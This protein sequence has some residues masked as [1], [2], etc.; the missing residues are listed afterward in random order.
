MLRTVVFILVLTC[1]ELFARSDSDMDG[2]E[3]RIDEC[4]NTPLSELVDKDGCTTASLYREKSFDFIY[5]VSLAQD[6]YDATADE[7]LDTFS[8]SFQF[9]YYYGDYSFQ[10]S[11]SVYDSQGETYTQSGSNDSFLGVYYKLPSSSSLIV[12]LGA[13]L[14]LPTYSSTLYENNT[15]FAASMNLSY[16]LDEINL[17]GAYCYTLINDKNIQVRNKIN[18]LSTAQINFQ[19]T[20]SLSAGLGFYPIE[21]LYLSAAYNSSESIYQDIDVMNTAS[22]GAF[23]NLNENWFTTAG[24]AYGLSESASQSYIS[25]RLGYY[26]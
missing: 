19:N 24:Y 25:L 9:D 21:K 4:P 5:G 12:R 18:T 17:F 8:Q 13:G 3:D 15:D 2:V 11:T 7:K 10:A 20:N 22:L 16:M 26:F 6:G 14:I 1:V 23:Y